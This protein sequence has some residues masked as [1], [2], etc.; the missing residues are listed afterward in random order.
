MKEENTVDISDGL[1]FPEDFAK[2]PKKTAIVIKKGFLMD[3]R[4]KKKAKRVKK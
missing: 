4:E 2:L 1:F 3:L